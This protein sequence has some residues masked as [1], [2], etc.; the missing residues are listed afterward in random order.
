MSGL[1]FRVRGRRARRVAGVR[2][3]CEATPLARAPGALGTQRLAPYGRPWV[4]HGDSGW[5]SCRLSPR[6]V[7]HLAQCGLGGCVMWIGEEERRTW[8]RGTRSLG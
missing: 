2:V 1:V 4:L 3:R 5:D 7:V 6:R 8:R